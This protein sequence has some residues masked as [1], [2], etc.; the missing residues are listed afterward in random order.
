MAGEWLL[1]ANA[2]IQLIWTLA[3][4]GI[5]GETSA[6]RGWQ[7]LTNGNLVAAA[8]G[9]SVIL[10]RDRLFGES[11]SKPLKKFSQLAVV[12]ITLDQAPAAE[13]ESAFAAAWNQGPPVP[14]PGEVIFWP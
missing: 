10:T 9:F 11:A 2:P 7:R 12:I 5:R 8:A 3:R 14:I 1:D 6:S 4:F 13:F